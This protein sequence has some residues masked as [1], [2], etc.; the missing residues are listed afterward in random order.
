[1][2]IITRIIMN[3]IIIYSYF[4][5]FYEYCDYIIIIKSWN[6][7]LLLSLK[8]KIVYIINTI[9]ICY[10]WSLYPHI[11]ISNTTMWWFNYIYIYIDIYIYIY[12]YIYD[13]NNDNIGDTINYYCYN[14]IN[15]IFIFVIV[16]I[17][18]SMLLLHNWSL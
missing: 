1:M 7:L 2:I 14:V 6:L 12:I 13:T 9:I 10:I 3:K 11:F 4:Y 8:I 17:V 15:V 18:I 16:D 5:E